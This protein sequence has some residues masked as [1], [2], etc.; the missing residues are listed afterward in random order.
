ML[1]TAALLF[2]TPMSFIVSVARNS[3]LMVDRLALALGLVI[4]PVLAFAKVELDL[5]WTG[6]LGGT[7]AYL[8]HR[9]RGAA[10]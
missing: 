10:Q 1:F 7:L 2:L 9:L 5:L 4:A 6:I 8:V 3:R